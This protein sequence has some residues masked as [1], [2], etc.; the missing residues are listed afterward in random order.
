MTPTASESVPNRALN[1][2]E[3]KELLRADFERLL[4]NDG[5]LSE[6]LAFGRVAYDIVLR[7]HLDNAATPLSESSIK[8]RT[9]SVQQ[10][11]ETP[12]LAAVESA[13]LQ[14][15]SSGAVAQGT[16]IQRIV[17]SPNQERLRLGLPI[18][19]DVRQADRTIVTE[20][21][22]YPKDESL[23][24]GNVQEQD[25]TKETRSAW[26]MLEQPQEVTVPAE[27]PDGA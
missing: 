21:V 12:Q 7:L 14:H 1:G 2:T 24:E 8:S 23:G 16:E 4:D 6:H 9:R 26:G 13:P 17:D 11:R 27:E 5:M 20:Q 3:L 10:V 25:V 22:R 18:P 19:V 15:P